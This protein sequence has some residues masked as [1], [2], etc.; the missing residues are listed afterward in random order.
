MT[1]PSSKEFL[2][3][4]ERLLSD[5][6]RLHAEGRC[7]SAATLVVVALEQTGAFVGAL[8]LEKCPAA[9]LAGK[10]RGILARSYVV[11]EPMRIAGIN[12]PE[13]LTFD[14]VTRTMRSQ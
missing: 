5:A 6:E 10:V 2:L 4:A 8:T 7:R 13:G 9:D 11:P 12:M 3:N 14:P 1:S